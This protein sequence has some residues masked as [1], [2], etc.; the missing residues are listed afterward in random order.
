MNKPKKEGGGQ[1]TLKPT[2]GEAVMGG[3]M[4]L[5]QRALHCGHRSPGAD[6]ITGHGGGRGGGGKDVEMR[7]HIPTLYIYDLRFRLLHCSLS[8]YQPLDL[9]WTTLLTV[10]CLQG[11]E[12]ETQ[13]GYSWL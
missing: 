13:T 5:T 12:G 1:T 2:V 11:K 10:L 8:A 6:L 3:S 7:E 4:V 9:Y